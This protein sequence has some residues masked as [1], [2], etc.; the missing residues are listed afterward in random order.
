[1]AVVADAA[2][3]ATT[4]T[5]TTTTTTIASGVLDAAWEIMS[6]SSWDTVVQ[7]NHSRNGA[8][9]VVTCEL[10][11]PAHNSWSL[12]WRIMGWCSD[13]SDNPSPL[14][15]KA[16]HWPFPHT[17][18]AHHSHPRLPQLLTPSLLRREWSIW[19]DAC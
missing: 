13:Q 15:P 18:P 16:K 19:K 6:S 10:I 5:T 1:M 17:P 11:E 8:L 4:T 3:A 12:L 14:S 2:A 9:C 7:S